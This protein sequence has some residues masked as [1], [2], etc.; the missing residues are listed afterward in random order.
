MPRVARRA[1]NLRASGLAAA[2]R[3]RLGRAEEAPKPVPFLLRRLHEPVTSDLP[4]APWRHVR[5]LKGVMPQV[6]GDE[7]DEGD[8]EADEDEDEIEV[9]D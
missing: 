9:E 6:V 8:E 5:G 2:K 3:L 1:A 4:P 7:G